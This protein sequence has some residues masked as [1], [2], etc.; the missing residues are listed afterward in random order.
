VHAAH[1]L[2]QLGP[3][4]PNAVVEGDTA[5]ASPTWRRAVWPSSW[6]KT[7]ATGGGG[8]R[9]GGDD[10]GFEQRWRTA[11]DRDAA[12]GHGGQDGGEAGK[13]SDR[14]VGAGTRGE[15]RAA[16]DSGGVLRTQDASRSRLL[17]RTRAW[18]M[19]P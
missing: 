12:P 2:A 15:V 10:V 5:E 3:G 16:S 17:T 14:G 19:T 18:R 13:A 8:E 1:G 11:S 7:T 4:L 9:P 6:A